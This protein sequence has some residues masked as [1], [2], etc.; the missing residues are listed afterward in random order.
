MVHACDSSYA[1]S[2]GW[3]ITVKGQ[4]GKKK[5]RASVLKK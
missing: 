4:L 5:V 2:I 1:G 3:G